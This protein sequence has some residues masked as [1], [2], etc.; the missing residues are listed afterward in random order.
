VVPLL[1]FN[2]L[3][4]EESARAGDDVT[5]TPKIDTRKATAI[6]KN[7]RWKNQDELALFPW[8]GMAQAAIISRISVQSAINMEGCRVP[9]TSINL[10]AD[11]R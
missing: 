3:H 8:K 6:C 10:L 4:A 1:A 9:E 5:T 11:S 7:D 2:V